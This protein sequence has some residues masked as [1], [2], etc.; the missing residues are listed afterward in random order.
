MLKYTYKNQ[1]LKFAVVYIGLPKNFKLVRL[2]ELLSP[3]EL[4]ELNHAACPKQTTSHCLIHMDKLAEYYCTSCSALACGDC[5]VEKHMNHQG[6]KRGTEILPHSVQALKG[7]IPS[8]KE[9][10]SNGKRSLTAMQIHSVS[11]E[12]QSMDTLHD[13][14]AYFDKLHSILT[15]R[16]EALK[17]AVTEQVEMGQMKLKQNALD[18][19]NSVQEVQKYVQELEQALLTENVDILLKEQ[20]L[21]SRLLSG[22][23]TLETLCKTST[24]LNTLSIEPPPLEDRKLEVFCQTLAVPIPTPLPHKEQEQISTAC[25]DYADIEPLEEVKDK[26]VSR[27]VSPSVPQPPLRKESHFFDSTIIDPELIWGATELMS[28]LF[29]S[30]TTSVYPRGVCCGVAGTVVITDVQNHRFQILAPTGKCINVFG[31]EG[32]SDGLFYEPMSVTADGKGNLLV[33]DI[34]PARVQKFSSD[35]MFLAF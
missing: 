6:V 30:A 34:K 17:H 33:C 26:S 18:L 14:K 9:T 15:E 1:N 16:E 29:H 28:A 12:K 11:L 35:G 31:K 3:L 8:A 5:L 2:I 24:T 4:E 10:L 32:H 25:S 13:I 7:L 19:S 23:Q 22:Q 27:S 21:K 20:Q